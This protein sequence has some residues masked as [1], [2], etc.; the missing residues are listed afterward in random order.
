VTLES[1]ASFDRYSGLLLSGVLAATAIW[2]AWDDGGGYLRTKMLA[3]GVTM[4]LG[5][6]ALVL[7]VTRKRCSFPPSVTVL[8][9]V[10]WGIAFLQSL[11]LPDGLV[12]WV[13]PGSSEV[14][15]D[16]IPAETLQE[17]LDSADPSL[18]RLVASVETPAV[19][20]APAFTRMA[21]AI[22][23]TFAI[24]AWLA[25][26]YCLLDRRALLIFF[27]SASVAGGL[28][29]FFGL[30]DAI[31]LSRD[32]E[33]ELRQRLIISPVGADDPFGPF[34]NNNNCAGYLNLTLGCT[35]G[36]FAFTIARRRGR[37]QR[38]DE[39]V[40]HSSSM[41]SK[42]QSKIGGSV[43]PSLALG[44]VAVVTVAGIIGSNSRGGF[45]GLVAGSICVAFYFSG[46]FR[47]LR[48]L[49][50]LAG[51]GLL[52][53]LVIDGLGMRERSG[54]RLQTLVEGQAL[55]DP[56]LGHWH[57]AFI[58]A[59]NFMPA[60]AG[61]GAY[62]YAYLPFQETGGERWFVNAD[63]MHMEWLV[64]GGLWLL[65]LI[66]IGL[67]LA[68]RD[69]TFLARSIAMSEASAT[70][71]GMEPTALSRALVVCAVYS[72]P[73]LIV[74]QCFDFGILM[75]SLF[76]TFAFLCGCVS[77]F[78]KD[79]KDDGMGHE[80]TQVGGVKKAA[81]FA[82]AIIAL[83][84]G[85]IATQELSVGKQIQEIENQRK[86]DR[87][88]LLVDLPSRV[89]EIELLQKIVQSD[90][91]NSV[92]WRN[93][94][95]LLIDEQRRLGADFLF[96]YQP[97]SQKSHASWV[98]P[99][100]LRRAVYL[101]KSEPRMGIDEL[102]LP[103][104]DLQTWQEARQHAMASL[105]RCPLDDRSRM[106][107]IQLDMVQPNANLAS[108]ELIEQAATLRSRND[109]VLKFLEQRAIE[110]PAGE[111]LESTRQR[112]GSLAKEK[113][114]RLKRLSTEQTGR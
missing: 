32:W 112:R 105:L 99:N 110:F 64:E 45:L 109:R 34:V 71:A 74:T 21:L 2:S 82:L 31:R 107:L 104:Q 72:F 96:E 36:L 69:S 38:S 92:A 41:S 75:P 67:V 84:G 7:A 58:A 46:G 101:N 51:I 42:Q 53:F 89:E 50:L 59:K 20:V 94:A 66:L 76:M 85:G 6:V 100:T 88:K 80:R 57:D 29:A 86:R 5:G 55:E 61:F 3:T 25:S 1:R 68:V 40:S 54:E 87:R 17:A 95:E 44:L 83:L 35:L 103:T 91:G 9:I 24:T 70:S 108:G 33:V 106:L 52:A 14:Y 47:K 98:S 4:V 65:P 19:S 114:E 37:K 60:G 62:R 39:F 93:L 11:P 49:G 56:R 8:A 28:F 73:A 113:Q 13:A 26:Y 78:A 77:R 23:I 27:A 22:P 79:V 111:A 16:W 43:L 12:G 10:V 63:G 30:A 15:S 90:P 81:V 97:E 18:E 48:V 102:L